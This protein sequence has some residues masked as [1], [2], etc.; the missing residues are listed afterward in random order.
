MDRDLVAR[1]DS[2][3]GAAAYRKK[4]EGSWIRR[5]SNRRELAVVRT[6]LARAQTRGRV[7][8]CP[9]GAGRLTPSLL[10]FAD[11]VI[12]ADASASMVAEAQ[13]ALRGRADAG[14]VTFITAS[15]AA[16]PLADDAVDTAVCHRLIHHMAN[17]D[18]RAPVWAELARVAKRRVV[19][20]FSDDST[21]KAR[22]QRRRG[23]DRRRSALMP[24][25]LNAE[26][27][28][29]GLMPI[30]EPIRLNGLHSLVAVAVFA[31]DG[32]A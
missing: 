8:D 11:H 1:Y 6:A 27:A 5:L 16:L 23:V 19:I 25:Q 30:G 13:D 14:E 9:C 20:S 32:G 4:Y 26:A 28:A 12:C 18:E 31:V 21:W 3:S 7:L 24:E 17:A 2:A 29:H 15:A 10:R 22:S